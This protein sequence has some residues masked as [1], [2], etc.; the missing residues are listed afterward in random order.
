MSTMTQR[1]KFIVFCLFFLSGFCSLL[2]Q[3]IW[4]RLAFASFGIVTPVLSVLISVFMAGIAIGSFYG[5]KFAER[6][7]DSKIPVVLY[8]GFAEM[9]IGLGAFAA[10]ALFKLGE[11]WL[12]GKGQTNSGAYMWNSAFIII[13]SI[14]PWCIAMGATIPLMMGFVRKMRILAEDS[15]SYLYLANALGAMTGTGLTALVLVEVMG[16]QSSLRLAACCNFAIAATSFILAARRRF[17]SSQGAPIQYTRRVEDIGPRKAILILFAT[18]FLSMAMEVIWTRAFTPILKTTIYSFA[19]LLSVYLLATWYGSFVYRRRLKSESLGSLEVFAPWLALFSILPLVFNDPRLSPGVA[20]VAVG[21]FPFCAGLGFL[22]PRIIDTYSNGIPGR[23][24][25]AYAWNVLGCIL[26]PIAAGYIMLP[27]IGVKWSMVAC[28]TPFVAYTFFT[29]LKPLMI[30]VAAVFLASTLLGSTFEDPKLYGTAQIRR[31]H[32]ATVISYGE[33][34]GKK[35]L[36]N[37]VGITGL[38]PV[39]KFMA[40][41]PLATLSEPPQSALVICFGMGTTF[42]SAIS[43]GIRTT[44]IELVPS[45]R[46]AF[47]YYFPESLHLLSESL[48]HVVIDDG[49]RFLRRDLEKYDL[50]TLDPPPPVE[51]SGSSLLYSTEFYSIA[52]THLTDRGLLQQWFPG[53]ETRIYNAVYVALLR[54]FAYVRVFRSVEDWGY[55]FLAADHF[56]EISGPEQLVARMPN[57]ARSDLMEWFPGQTVEKVLDHVLR[58]EVHI[59]DDSSGPGQTY[60]SDDRPFNEYY[61]LRRIYQKIRFGSIPTQ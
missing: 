42:R 50:I 22:T 24:G 10:P 18:G 56:I 53:G 16:F 6:T 5:G 27:L 20:H 25:R 12:L 57:A 49:R 4:L 21:I 28:A 44:A 31:D 29:R 36:V 46:D 48:G 54:S 1:I 59:A 43:W 60:I 45:V 58:N 32:T 2:Y 11:T 41:L 7:I 8:Y 17:P 39:T 37:G 13:A 33:G 3:V 47:G 55:H 35:L 23:A 19:L 38:T 30:G 40:H 61:L 34:M 52:K 26:G 15:F 14:L 51:A 9:I